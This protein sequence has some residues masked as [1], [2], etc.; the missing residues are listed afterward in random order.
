MFFLTALFVDTYGK[1]INNIGIR[2]FKAVGR[3]ETGY[4]GG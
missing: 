1:Q 4:P 3:V 2:V